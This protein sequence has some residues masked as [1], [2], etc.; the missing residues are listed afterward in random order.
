MAG[1]FTLICRYNRLSVMPSADDNDTLDGTEGRTAIL[2]PICNEEV[3]RV[4]AGLA[5]TYR[6]L[7]ETGQ[8]GVR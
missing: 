5:A 4:F 8:K 1:L 6:S 2:M 7:E 3:D